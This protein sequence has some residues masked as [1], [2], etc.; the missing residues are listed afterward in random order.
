MADEPKGILAR[1]LTE[2]WPAKAAGGILDALMLP[3]QVA[4]GI[5]N[6]KPE[7]PG[8]WSDTDEAR[9]QLTN[10][11]MM[12]RA[13]DLGGL[14]MLGGTGAAT[15][16][17]RPGDATLGVVPV[18]VARAL[19]TKR[20]LPEGDTFAAA[21]RNTPGAAVNDGMLTMN[22][23]RNQ[24]P[25]QAMSE[26]VRGGVFYLPQ[27]SKD[28]KYYS[29]TGHNY[30]YG[31]AER[32]AGETA[33]SNPL[34]V[35]GAT[36]G[37]APEAAYDQMLGKGAYQKMRTDA[38]HYGIGQPADIKVEAAEKF[39]QQYAP[40]MA[41]L[42]G[43]IVAN[44]SKGNQ[45]AYALQEAAVAS[46]AR[47]AGHD[48]VVGYSVSRKTKEPFISELYDVRENLY[49]SKSGEYGIWDMFK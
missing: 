39:L 42:A 33:V 32:I 27:G 24:R 43:H 40:E 13:T 8:Y 4:G 29:G 2:T 11:T 26:S 12:Q 37:K 38:L 45:M 20:A 25:E 3:G 28:A 31:G 22:V 30:A 46:A 49:P 5:L 14:M 47:K 16:T 1:L 41:D 19:N 15:A 18:D 17:L 9:S 10:Q 35:K 23:T 21:V 6:V 7:R 34:F 48:S 36:G 44:S